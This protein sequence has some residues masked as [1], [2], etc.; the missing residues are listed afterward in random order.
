MITKIILLGPSGMLGN[1]IYMYF[2]NSKYNIS[3]IS[4]DKYR[5]SQSTLHSINEV[6]INKG[7]NS[8]T[9]VI[10]CI[11]CIPQRK[12][13]SNKSDHNY[14][15]VNGIFPHILWE[16]CKRHGAKLIHPTTD[17]VFNGARG[18]YIESDLHDETNNYGISKSVG[19]PLDCTIIRCSIIGKEKFNKKSLLEFILQNKG[20]TIQG[21]DSHMWNGITCLEY[22]KVIE[23]IL[24]NNWFWEGIRHIL[25]PSPVS[26]YEL[27]SIIN[28]E[29]DLNIQINKFTSS[30]VD[31]TLATI[32]P[33]SSKFAINNLRKQIK[34]LRL[35]DI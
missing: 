25:S 7:I 3:T 1:Y 9:C 35:F 21:Y 17:C 34:E 10:N 4:S 8:E 23:K 16:A 31:K 20:G 32:F 14:F 28:E 26:K 11:G 13:P 24:Y 22:C 6:L 12:D 19:E 5:V 33:E 30:I 27:C 15:I 29:F 2:K 18:N